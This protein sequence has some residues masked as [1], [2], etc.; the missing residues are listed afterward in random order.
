MTS[1][2]NYA[3]YECSSLTHISIP[4]SVTSFGNSSYS[5]CSSLTQVTFEIP[6]SVTSIGNHAFYCCLSLTQIIIPPSVTSIYSN[7]F[8]KCAS[9]PANSIQQNLLGENKNSISFWETEL[10]IQ[11]ELHRVI[12]VATIDLIGVKNE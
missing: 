1:I 5:G 7:A 6:S 9:L 10:K 2:G 8:N 11:A 3:F 12:K 4:S